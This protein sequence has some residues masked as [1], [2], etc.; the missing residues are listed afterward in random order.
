MIPIFSYLTSNK[1]TINSLTKISTEWSPLRIKHKIRFYYTIIDMI[2]KLR[3][4]AL[5]RQHFRQ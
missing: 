2:N 1:F 5:L 3:Y 4:I